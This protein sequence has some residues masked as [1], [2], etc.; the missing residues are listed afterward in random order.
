MT[1]GAHVGTRTRGLLLTKEVLCQL[2]YMGLT[3]GG[4]APR[5][6]TP[7][8]HRVPVTRPFLATPNCTAKTGSRQGRRAPRRPHNRRPQRALRRFRRRTTSEPF[9]PPGADL[10]LLESLIYA[11]PTHHTL[12]R[13]RGHPD[14]QHPVRRAPLHLQ[15]DRRSGAAS[16]GFGRVFESGTGTAV[17][18]RHPPVGTLTFSIWQILSL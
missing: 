14:P 10:P 8:R 6:M 11:S 7:H 18:Y 1:V 4:A 3:A 17:K 9:A 16:G 15:R 2:S 12:S 5:E 13:P